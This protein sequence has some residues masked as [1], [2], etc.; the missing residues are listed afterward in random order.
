M[1]MLL[2]KPGLYVQ[3]PEGVSEESI[4]AKYAN[5]QPTSTGLQKMNGSMWKNMK[6]AVSKKARSKESVRKS[7]YRNDK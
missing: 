4:R 3:H 5:I 6:P 7:A 2:I 1:R